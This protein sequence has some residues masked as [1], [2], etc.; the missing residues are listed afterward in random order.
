MKV[1]RI[2][3]AH[4]YTHTHTRT[5]FKLTDDG[6]DAFFFLYYFSQRIREPYICGLS[7]WQA[8]FSTL[9]AEYTRL[10]QDACT[11]KVAAAAIRLN[12]CAFGASQVC[13]NASR[14]VECILVSFI[15]W[16]LEHILQT[17]HAILRC[18]AHTSPPNAIIQFAV[19]Y[20]EPIANIPV[21]NP[22]MN[23]QSIQTTKGFCR[24]LINAMHAR[25]AAVSPSN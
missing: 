21:R 2:Y 8:H 23:S 3:A 10:S 14:N 4:G 25:V 24:V 11:A 22:S 6:D 16:H 19:W 17:M 20:R 1:A 15:A 13:E 9:Y 5:H 12:E 18:T 7:F